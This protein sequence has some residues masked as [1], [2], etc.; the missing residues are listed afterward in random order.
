M[1]HGLLKKDYI[2]TVGQRTA[3]AVAAGTQVPASDLVEAGGTDGTFSKQ[4]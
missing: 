4:R 1:D 3:L 2:V